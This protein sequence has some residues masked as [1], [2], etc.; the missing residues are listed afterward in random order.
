MSCTIYKSVNCKKFTLLELIV[1]IAIIMILASILLPALNKSKQTGQRISCAGNL[2]QVYLTF[3]YY[4]DDSN[5]W[6]PGW[7]DN[8]GYWS[9]KLTSLYFPANKY[10]NPKPSGYQINPIF[11]CPS[12]TIVTKGASWTLSNV[13]TSYGTNGCGGIQQDLWWVWQTNYYPSARRMDMLGSK[14]MIT[15]TQYVYGAEGVVYGSNVLDRNKVYFSHNNQANVLFTAG[16]VK[17]GSW[18]KIYGMGL[19]NSDFPWHY[20]SPNF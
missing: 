6:Y 16:H 1:V 2:K 10:L 20:K 15:D 17:N 5:G 14:I 7:S 11:K 12:D 4:S 8:D 18:G 13:I 19:L 3:R 9:R